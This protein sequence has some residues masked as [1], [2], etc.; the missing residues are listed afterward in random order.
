MN[1]VEIAVKTQ[2]IAAVFAE[3]LEYYEPFYRENIKADCD[4]IKLPEKRR[5]QYVNALNAFTELK[6]KALA[7][8]GILEKSYPKEYDEVIDKLHEAIEEIK[9]NNNESART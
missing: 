7:M 2:C 4:I 8:S 9:I 3:Y 5:K 6:T 1:H